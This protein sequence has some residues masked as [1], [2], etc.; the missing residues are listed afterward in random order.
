MGIASWCWVT[1]IYW[2]FFI[3]PQ[4][5]Q[6]STLLLQFFGINWFAV[7]IFIPAEGLFIYLLI[8][9]P[10]TNIYNKKIQVINLNKYVCR[11][12]VENQNM[13]CC[14]A[15]LNIEI[16]SVINFWSLLYDPPAEN[17]HCR[18]SLLFKF[19][20]DYYNFKYSVLDIN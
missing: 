18:V 8:Y 14:Q 9:F 12:S 13:F 20:A 4:Q 17:A 19:K 7:A 15:P 11:G 1:L 3:L 6:H 5:S 10:N 16:V 2:N